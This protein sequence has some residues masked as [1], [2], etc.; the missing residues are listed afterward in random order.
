MV[1]EPEYPETPV[2]VPGLVGSASG[3]VDFQAEGMTFAGV[4]QF[5]RTPPAGVNGVSLR[6]GRG[7]VF[8]GQGGYYAP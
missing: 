4:P 3:T 5:G 2:L 7:L 8:L 1:I 6:V